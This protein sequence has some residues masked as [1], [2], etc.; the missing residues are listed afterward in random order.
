MTLSHQQ[1]LALAAAHGVAQIVA[2]DAVEK[3]RRSSAH[4][5]ALRDLSIKR[6]K[7]GA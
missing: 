4:L 7:R 6:I 5:F 2:E 3:A 1:L